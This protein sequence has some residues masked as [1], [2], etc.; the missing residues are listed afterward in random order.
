MEPKASTRKKTTRATST[1]AKA[2]VSRIKPEKS[3]KSRAAG[4]AF[5]APDPQERHRLISEAAYFRAEARGFVPG[6][7]EA[8]WLEAEQEIKKA[9]GNG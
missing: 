2:T 3:A 9:V 1:K 5:S 8:D 6:F 4:E 7:E